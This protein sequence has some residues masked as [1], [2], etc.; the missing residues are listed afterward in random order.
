MADFELED[1]AQRQSE[2]L[3]GHEKR[4]RHLRE[5]IEELERRQ[6]RIEA[7]MLKNG[8]ISKERMPEH[9][10]EPKRSPK[11]VQIPIY[12]DEERRV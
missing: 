3:E 9:Q 1:R 6:D 8:L 10:Q 12:H 2:I 4:L 11:S 5:E 7:I